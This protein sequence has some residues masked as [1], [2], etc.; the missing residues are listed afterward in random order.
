MGLAYVWPSAVGPWIHI[1]WTDTVERG[2]VGLLEAAAVVVWLW[3]GHWI[4]QA[5]TRIHRMIGWGVATWFAITLVA[6]G[7]ADHSAMGAVR[8][9]EW[10][11]HLLFAGVVWTEASHA[12]QVAHAWRAGALAGAV[13]VL[14]ACLWNWSQMPPP[15]PESVLLTI[16]FV[17]GVR[18]IGTA[19]LVA[20]TLGVVAV[21][22]RE[23][24]APL[25]AWSTFGWLCIWW[26]GSRGALG[27]ALVGV[28]ALGAVGALSRRR[29]LA[30]GV[31]SGLGALATVPI[32][33]PEFRMGI[34]HLW[35]AAQPG[36]GGYG[37]GRAELW[38]TTLEG[39]RQSPWL[40]MGPDGVFSHLAPVG[41]AHA[42]NTVVQAL[43]EWGILG[44]TPFVVTLALM[45]G[46]SLWLARRPGPRAPIR[47]GATSIL[48]AALANGL[49]DGLF[50]D[51]A[52]TMLT[53][54][55]AAVALACEPVSRAARWTRPALAL[56]LVPA[57]A[58][59]AL[60]LAVL[61]ALS[62]PETPA[63]GSPRIQLVQAFPSAPI[64]QPV[65]WW[66]GDWGRTHSSAALELA[67]WG[68]AQQRGPWLMLV[69]R[70][71]IY[72]AQGCAPCAAADFARAEQLR[73]H[74]VRNA[75]PWFTGS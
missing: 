15:T 28:V 49:L 12:R 46:A 23:R 31:G 47:A 72:G 35:A 58:L 71:Q 59:C 54:S 32:S 1:D 17:H 67:S 8:T 60:H 56:A 40:G 19:G 75:P 66:V 34:A 24:I 37:S 42:H 5:P 27:A 57:A 61:R 11:L 68:A 20:V 53:V 48:A 64:L 62:A 41:S 29:A 73:R 7:G 25:V 16:P 26:S 10:T 33:V 30:L 51:P 44:A 38:Q 14:A 52:V 36:R 65:A 21:G 2:M 13:P 74:A 18:W 69:A 3:R 22:E 4:P 43:G 70:G 39:W 55:A 63:P 9:A 50:Y 6:L 45:L